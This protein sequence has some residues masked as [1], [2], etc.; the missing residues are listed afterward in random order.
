MAVELRRRGLRLA[1]ASGSSADVIAAELRACGFGA[2][3]FDF[4]ISASEVK[5]GKP[6]PD[7]FLEAAKRLG[8]PSEACLVI[9]D[10]RYGVAAA[11][12]AG[13]R[14]LALPAEAARAQSEF[15]L[16]DIVSPNG[17]A[18]LD[19]ATVLPALERLGLPT[20]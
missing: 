4:T 15:E 9:E 8:L 14:C 3:L 7:I 16:A 18:A 13:M 10:S 1:V 5:R 20:V 12:R 17:A 2:D 19:L 11:G 6:E